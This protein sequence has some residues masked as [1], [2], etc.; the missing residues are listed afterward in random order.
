MFRVGLLIAVTVSLLTAL[1]GAPAPAMAAKRPDIVMF[2]IDDWAPLPYRLWDH[3]KRT[4]ELARFVD[5]GV[6]FRNAIASTP[7]CGPARAN[8]L[9]GQYGHRNGVTQ[10]L[11]DQYQGNEQ[12]STKLRG[13]GYRTAFVG[14]HINGLAA[15]YPTRS[16]MWNLAR[17]WDRFDVIWHNQGRYYGWRQYRKDGTGSYGAAPT[18]HSSYQAA[19]R[20]VDFVKSTPRSK[21]LFM[22]VS[23][24]DGHSPRTPM[25]RHQGSWKCK[26]IQP[27]ASPS[28]NE[29]D[30]SD[31]PK[32]VRNTFRRKIDAVGLR[33]R[34]EEA[35]TVDW[36][37]GQV[38]RALA[39]EGRVSN[40]LQ[41]FTADNGY[42]L[43]DHRLFGKGYPYSV[44]VPLYM[45]WPAVMKD[46]RRVVTEPVSNVDFARTF[47]VLAGCSLPGSDGKSL[48]PLLKRWRK[49]LDR[50]YLYAEMLHP[51]EHWGNRASARPAW[52]QIHST[53]AYSDR[54]WTFTRYHNGEEELYDITNDPH[55]L[56]NV[57]HKAE[58]QQ[59]R[60]DLRS[61]WKAVKA[62]G[63]VRWKSKLR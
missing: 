28:F 35:L 33:T 11:M 53:H 39:A 48:V 45:R 23:L 3:D 59:V 4:P 8:L 43:G 15:A 25:A 38:R 44:S 46:K 12:I 21:P 14:K 7:L 34:C 20:A 13:S 16:R 5:K 50:K 17:R 62:R 41:I 9:T 22:V 24:Y 52:V 10:N 32:Y 19:K 40:T 18:D 36:V 57:V 58:Y 55:K 56:K 60:A 49:Q 31:K 2:Y 27:W 42:L 1:L 30:V 61:F 37:I 47:C 6:E 54:L 51:G 29:K 26:S 63:D